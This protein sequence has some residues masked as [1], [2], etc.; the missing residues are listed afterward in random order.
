[1]RALGQRRKR[2]QGHQHDERD[3]LPRVDDGDGDAGRPSFTQPADASETGRVEEPVDDPEVGVELLVG[4]M[5][6]YRDEVVA[7]RDRIAAGSV[8]RPVRTRGYGIHAGWG[9]GGWF[10]DQSL[11]AEAR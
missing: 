9:P 5:W 7:T 6:R 10:S 11:A 2:S 1:M 3:G 8:G 4:H